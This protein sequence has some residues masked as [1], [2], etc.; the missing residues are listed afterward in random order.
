MLFAN[1]TSL[2]I[3]IVMSPYVVGN[4]KNKFFLSAFVP[5]LLR[6]LRIEASTNKLIDLV[7]ELSSLACLS[8]ISPFIKTPSKN[9]H[10]ILH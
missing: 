6:S 4:V 8:F 7:L 9:I 5:D 1:Q 2:F 3:R 10:D